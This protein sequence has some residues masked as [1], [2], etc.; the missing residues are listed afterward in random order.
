MAEIK[1]ITLTE[2]CASVLAWLQ[3]NDNGEVGYF[4][5]EIAEAL[6]LNAKGIHG[7]MNSLVKNALVGKGTREGKGTDKDGNEIVKTYTT[8][9]LT[10]A[11][12]AFQA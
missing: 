3:A 1:E 12:R 5:V 7:V 10:D 11:G 8:Y 6:E 2:K 9:F 4:G